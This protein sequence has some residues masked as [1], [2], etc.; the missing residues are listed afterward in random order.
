MYGLSSTIIATGPSV[1]GYYTKYLATTSG[2]ELFE[3][4]KPPP[5]GYTIQA[6]VAFWGLSD[7]EYQAETMGS[8]GP[9][10]W[11]LGD[12]YSEHT[13][14]LYQQA[15]PITWT[16]QEDTPMYLVH[17]LE[18][19]WHPWRQTLWM[20][21]SL[22]E[23]DVPCSPEYFQDG[24]GYEAYGGMQAAADTLIEQI[25]ILLSSGRTADLNLDDS[26]DVTDILLVIDHWGDCPDLP[27]DCPAD[28]DGDEAVLADDL[29]MVLAAFGTS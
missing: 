12:H 25:P 15:S 16:D 23:F 27:V 9:L 7:L 10:A 21:E 17:G 1:G 20:H 28:L 24:H 5:G 8:S 13:A 2:V 11:F 19:A 29:L 3:P 18:D 22:A 26:I 4:L 14:E 6:G